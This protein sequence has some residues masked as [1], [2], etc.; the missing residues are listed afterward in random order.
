MSGRGKSRD[1]LGRS[2]GMMNVSDDGLRLFNCKLAQ[3][4]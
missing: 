4:E 1:K 2:V 3:V